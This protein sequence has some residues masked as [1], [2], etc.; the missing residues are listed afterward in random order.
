MEARKSLVRGTADSSVHVT[1][2]DLSSDLSKLYDLG[3]G[4]RALAQKSQDL[5]LNLTSDPCVTG[6]AP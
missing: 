2:R 4:K 5:G 3:T 6:E 1:R